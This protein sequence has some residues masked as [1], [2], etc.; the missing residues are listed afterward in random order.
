MD[1]EHRARI[2]AL[3]VLHAGACAKLLRA[4]GR[5]GH[6]ANLEAAVSEV[7]QIVANY[8]GHD[9]LTAALDWA[10]D[11]LWTPAP[12]P[13]PCP[14]RMADCSK[15]S[16]PLMIR[17]A[18]RPGERTSS[19]HS[20]SIKSTSP[21]SGRERSLCEVAEDSTMRK[22]Y[23]FL[24]AGIALAA[25]S[26][27]TRAQAPCEQR[28]KIVSILLQQF[29]EMQVGSG[30]TPNGQLLEL[31]ASPTR[32]SWTILLSM[33]TGK[34]CMI[35]TGEDWHALGERPKTPGEGA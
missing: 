8:L 12:W 30:I 16:C 6:A 31:F 26:T 35:A 27:P 19:S 34:S 22:G 28:A 4:H 25:L 23:T 11:Q 3:S 18:G 2:A 9:T 13:G 32:G 24:A 21:T 33:P 20:R 7:T 14:R 29:E 15:R 1:R 17:A 5:A 10:S